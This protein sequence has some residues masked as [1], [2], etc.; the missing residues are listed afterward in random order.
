MTVRIL[1]GDCREVLKGLPDESVNEV[2]TSP[3]YW[4]LRDYGTGQDG[5]GL[6]PTLAEHLAALVEVFREVRRVLRS[7]GAAI[8]KLRHY[9][10]RPLMDPEQRAAT[11][12]S[13]QDDDLQKER[14][15][16]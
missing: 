7:D 14:A 9:Y 16:G 3:P 11:S 6:E 13:S 15:D 4:G 10:V 5:I 12:D 8:S 1:T 2:V